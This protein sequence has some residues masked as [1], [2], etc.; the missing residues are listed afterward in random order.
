MTDELLPYY[1]KELAYLTRMGSE[2]AEAHPKIAGRLRM[3][4]DA[5]E[6]PHVARLIEGVAYLNA[7]IR[8]KLDDAFPEISEALLG[9][10]YPHYL[11]PIP[12][13]AIVQFVLDPEQGALSEGYT[14][15]RHSMVETE[16]IDGLPCRFRTG[17]PVRLWPVELKSAAFQGPPFDVPPNLF[18]AETR[19]VVRLVLECMSEKV[20]FGQMPLGSLR[21]FLHGPSHS[22]YELYELLLNDTLALLVASSPKDAEPSVVSA[23]QQ[24][25]R[26]VGFGRDEGLLPYSPRSFPG[27]RLLSEY[28]SCPQKFLFVEVTG[29]NPE[30]L[31]RCG[32]RL[33]LFFLLDRYSQDLERSVTKDTFQLGCTPMVNL[34]R[35]PAEPIPVSHTEHEY[36][37]V[38]DSRRPLAHEIYAIDRVVAVSSDGEEREFH[39]FYSINRARD[40]RDPET[41]WY[42]ARRPSS[43]LAGQG[44]Q[45]TELFLT[46]VDLAFQPSAPAD[47][48]LHVETTCLNRDL[49]RRLEFGGGAPFLQLAVAAPL[50]NVRCLTPP[51]PTHRPPFGYG[52]LWQL[53]S[54]LSLNHLSLVDGQDGAEALREILLL[55]DFTNSSETR[56]RIGGLLSVGAHRVVGRVGGEV[57]A[58]FCRGLEIT[59]HFDEERFSDGG[60][61]LFAAVLEQFLSLYSSINSFTKVIA[62]TNQREKALRRWPPRSGEKILL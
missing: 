42:A 38:P 13:M 11:A 31:A 41:F 43:H 14:I 21:F 62:T 52:T 5:T 12:S 17:Y 50:A 59:L 20:D 48:T 4:P 3:G 7:R 55:Y 53:I 33:E 51:T 23:A 30:T 9:V 57:A 49:P 35:Q 36:R 37:V 56:H 26:P 18:A 28:F 15:P 32:N 39:P 2:F 10:L 44:A 24:P 22:I 60:V 61:F 27:Y 8:H 34:Y 46:L 54:H 40:D 1:K 45:G 16:P 25:V 58:G 19:A 29:F 47:W 6:D